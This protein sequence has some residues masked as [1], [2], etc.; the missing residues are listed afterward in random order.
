MEK[1]E[2]KLFAV[3]AFLLLVFFFGVQAYEPTN[4]ITT[5]THLLG[6]G[7]RATESATISHNGKDYYVVKVELNGE[8]SGF[9]A[10]D[11]KQERVIE[12][13]DVTVKKLFQTAKFALDY[14]EFKAQVE[15]NPSL[16]WFLLS[17]NIVR[18]IARLLEDEKNDLDIIANQLND[19][20]ATKK[21]FEMKA[22]LDEMSSM[23]LELA[24][25][26]DEANSLE[27][28]LNQKS[29]R[30]ETAIESD[31]KNSLIDV[32]TMLREIDNSAVEYNTELKA[33]QRIISS[34]GLNAESQ[35][36]LIGYSKPPNDFQLI[37]NWA[38][39]I[40][41]LKEGIESVYD[42][43]IASSLSL[44][45]SF[46][47]R[48][49]KAKAF[50]V[51][52]AEDSDLFKK[53]N[54]TYKSVKNAAESMLGSE[55]KD[56]WKNQESIALLETNWN[57]A[58]AYFEKGDYEKAKSF[59]LKAKKN[60]IDIF[61]EG[62]EPEHLE[63]KYRWDLLITGSILIIIALII[64]YALKNRRKIAGLVQKE[65]TEEEVS[66]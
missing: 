48:I 64:I 46:N 5:K 59:G 52:F 1:T 44:V 28:T 63:P 47:K 57:K 38:S 61:E 54:N 6:Q 56:K 42:N 14:S 20:E 37:G 26:M 39:S 23:L 41:G 13:E 65:E 18:N 16:T 25:K 43:A 19:M 45:Q 10:L 33:L 55:L 9:I 17:T 66:F 34:S 22:K 49:E 3:A 32:F 27:S 29:E 53:T 40:E 51:L 8:F 11:K 58:Q 15:S 2:K 24:D 31:L 4:Y 35:K 7:E 36:S 62:L 30:L 12:N 60:I 21:V 50:E